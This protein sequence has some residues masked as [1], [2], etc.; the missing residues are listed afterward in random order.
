MSFIVTGLM[1]FAAKILATVT[2]LSAVTQKDAS[3]EE[4]VDTVNFVYGRLKCVNFYVW[5]LSFRLSSTADSW[6][7]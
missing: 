5:L 2:F 1:A 4:H 7:H 6:P 3:Y